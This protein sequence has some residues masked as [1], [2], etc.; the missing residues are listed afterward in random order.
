VNLCFLLDEV[1]Y[2]VE[3]PLAA[4]SQ[5]NLEIY[6]R[7]IAGERA[8]DLAA[9]YRINWQRIYQIVKQVNETLKDTAGRA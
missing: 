6:C 3:R 9:E 8:V 2:P 1:E 5:R 4:P 7:Y